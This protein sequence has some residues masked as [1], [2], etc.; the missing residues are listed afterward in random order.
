MANIHATC[1]ELNGKGILLTGP[2]GVGKS[3]TALRL[4][5]ALNAV[6]VA[7]DQTE[8]KEH[9]GYIIASCPSNIQ[10]LLEVRGIGIVRQPSKKETQVNLIVELVKNEKEVDRLPEPQYWEK[11]GVK[12]KKIKLYPFTPSAIYKIKLACD[13]KEFVG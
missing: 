6:L 12:I 3:D 5:E 11:D 7:D 10:G 9:G 8:L 4:I 1:V 13:E 2:S